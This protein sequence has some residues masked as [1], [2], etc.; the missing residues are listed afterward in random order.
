MD[1]TPFPLPNSPQ[2]TLVLMKGSVNG[3]LL[4]GLI[5]SLAGCGGGGNGG[6][7]TQPPP[8]VAISITPS[9]A[10]VEVG[11]MQQFNATVSNTTNSAVTWQAG[12]VSGGNSTVGTISSAGLYT[13]PA[14]VPNPATVT[15]TA[16]AQADSTKSASALVTVTPAPVSISITPT[17]AS[18]EVGDTQQFTSTVSN[19]PNSAVTWQVN[20]ITGGNTTVGTVSTMGLY[21]A[22]AVVPSPATVTVAAVAQADSTKSASATVT[23]TPTIIVTVSPSSATVT[24]NANQQFTATVQNTTD[25]AVTWQVNGTTG[26]SAT[27][28]T[29][30]TVGLFTAPSAPPSGGTV[31]VTAVS[32]AD[33]SKSGSATVTIGFS[34]ASLN[35]Q[36]AFSLQDPVGGFCVVGSFEA[37]GNGALAQGILD[38]NNQDNDSPGNPGVVATSVAFTGSYQIT[39][40]GRGVLT[41]VL[42]LPSSELPNQ[43]AF[44]MVSTA[45]GRM[46]SKDVWPISGALFRQIASAFSNGAI[47]GNYA[48]RY[49]GLALKAGYSNPSP[50]AFAGAFT[51]DGKGNISVGAADSNFGGTVSSNIAF[52]GSYNVG[53]NGRGTAAFVSGP[54]SVYVV[55]ASKL[56]FISVDP[57]AAFTGEIDQQTGSP[58]SDV[59]TSGGYTFALTGGSDFSFLVGRFTADGQGGIAGGE[60]DIVSE[61][62]VST[63]VAF[64][65]AFSVS[66]SGRG[67]MALTSSLGTSNFAFYLVSPSQAFLVSADPSG[68]FSGE[69]YGQENGP[70]AI[71]GS[72]AFSFAGFLQNAAQFVASGQLTADEAGTIQSGTEDSDYFG[73]DQLTGT[74][75][76]VSSS[77]RG[78]LTTTTAIGT[79]HFIF[80]VTSP[81]AII[82]VGADPA[83]DGLGSDAKQF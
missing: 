39:V 78:T 52:T 25:S 26:G 28:G 79:S 22:P 56:M 10:N 50:T 55:S 63:D 20:G 4:A 65:G 5:L 58:F 71:E 82:L 73:P 27:V 24:P 80:Y 13:A 47:A 42:P 61:Q 70:F 74:Y 37:D 72:Y 81:S 76:S 45:E 11:G 38:L 17:T 1:R 62:G 44:V 77:G 75:S 35:G 12:G 59:S 8:A 69:A 41:L 19:S 21:T 68:S 43:Y 31:T 40:D 51:A 57:S 60:E 29:I 7:V 3:F 30:S 67:T 16:I 49:A 9:T 83:D 54:L 2:V 34:N 53:A 64:T 6:G 66:P 32:M 33:P 18:V 14:A 48:F 15:V 36:Y 46:I 23:V